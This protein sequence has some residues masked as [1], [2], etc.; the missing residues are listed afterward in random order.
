MLIEEVIIQIK[1]NRFF[2][3]WEFVFFM[4]FKVVLMQKEILVLRKE[5]FKMNE[6]Q[7]KIFDIFVFVIMRDF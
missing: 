2:I 7:V 3:K 4:F 6:V 1:L 5:M